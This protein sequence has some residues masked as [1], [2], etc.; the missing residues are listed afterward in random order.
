[1]TR[2]NKSDIDHLRECWI[3][4]REDDDL[5]DGPEPVMTSVGYVDLWSDGAV[6]FSPVSLG[7]FDDDVDWTGVDGDWTSVDADDDDDDGEE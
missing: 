2:L 7:S 5:A 6:T 4:T 3:A 1:M